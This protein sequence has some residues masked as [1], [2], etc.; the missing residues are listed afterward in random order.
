VDLYIHSLVRLYG[1]VLNKL[2]TWT[3][4]PLPLFCFMHNF[5]T[6]S[7]GDIYGE[8]LKLTEKHLIRGQ[9]ITKMGWFTL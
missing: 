2:S 9:C 7:T 8:L 1:T 3:I 6:Y 5:V 4:L